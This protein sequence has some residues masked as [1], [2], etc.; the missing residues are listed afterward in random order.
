MFSRAKN[1]VT[2][3]FLDEEI[4]LETQI[5]S[6]LV[7]RQASQLAANT[8]EYY[9]KMLHLFYQFCE[10]QRVQHLTEIKTNTI[11]EYL[12][13]LQTKGHNP[14]GIHACYRAVRVFLRWWEVEYEPSSW[15][16][17]VRKE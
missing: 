6:F 1:Q 16:N 3:E 5:A 7:D 12:L 8:I 2:I 10:S 14:G 13:L 9:R 15:K 11:R 4:H 17:P